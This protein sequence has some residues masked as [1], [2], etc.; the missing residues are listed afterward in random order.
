M[1]WA[2][3]PKHYS[4]HTSLRSIPAPAIHLGWQITPW[5]GWGRYGL[6]LAAELRR[7][8]CAVAVDGIAGWNECA[9]T[10]QTALAGIIDLSQ[11]PSTDPPIPVAVS[12]QAIGNR[13]SRSPRSQAIAAERTM[14][15]IFSEDTRWLPEEVARLNELSAIIAGS[16]W[17]A[18]VLRAAGVRNVVTILQG[19]DPELWC[20]T[21]PD[22]GF[23][24]RLAGRFAV[25]SGGKLEF[26]KGQDIV[27]A[28]FRRFHSLHPDAVLVT[29]WQNPWPETIR[30]IDLAGHVTGLPKVVTSAAGDSLDL[31]AWAAAERIER[32]AFIDLGLLAGHEL[33][34]RVRACDLAVF[35]NR[36]EGGTNLVAMECLAAGL[37]T[38]LSGNTGHLDLADHAT[39]LSRQGRVPAG[40]PFYRDMTGW[41]E[42][43]VDDLVAAMEQGY[44]QRHAPRAALEARGREFAARCSWEENGRQ[45]LGVLGLAGEPLEGSAASGQSGT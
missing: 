4:M 38:V 9:A 41:G 33:P 43:S 35:A 30:G 26:R 28:A 45:M 27:L 21:A 3:L 14:G 11:R 32:N 15:V 7:A 10:E 36:A 2:V 42:T 8:G 17:N 29:A 6:N 31:A 34:R 19:I 20:Q 25:F 44:A 1:A 23:A 22:R 37:P 40:C 13:G 5:T 39:M 16:A 12:L 18:A 24:A